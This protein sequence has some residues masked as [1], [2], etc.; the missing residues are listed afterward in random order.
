MVSQ[1]NVAMPEV[2]ISTPTV[3]D[4]QEENE[5]VQECDEY[6]TPSK[7]PVWLIILLTVEATLFVAFLI[8][9]LFFQ[10]TAPGSANAFWNAAGSRFQENAKGIITPVNIIIY[11]IVAM[12]VIPLQ[13]VYLNYQRKK[14]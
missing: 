2:K 6:A 10:T 5:Q 4:Y 14:S 7:T 1:G 8:A 13:L 11:L 12:I 9:L 3:I